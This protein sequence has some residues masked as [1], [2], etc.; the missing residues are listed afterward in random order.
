MLTCFDIGG[1]R[2]KPGWAT[3]PGRL[4]LLPEVPTP[5]DFAGLV[6]VMAGAVQPGSR[7]VSVS[8]AGVVPPETGRLNA[9]NVAAAHGHRLAVDLQAALG[10]P[11]WIANDA[12][13]FALAEATL[14]AGRGHRNLFGLIL[15]S[16]VGGG[17]VIDG[18][19]VTGVGGY[20]G[21]WGHGQVLAERLPNLGLDIPQFPCGC[22]QQGCID[23][24]GGA[25]GIERLYRHI[26]GT[27]LSSTAILSD[28]LTAEPL[29]LLVIDAWVA[30]LAGPLA[31]VLN[32]TGSSAVPVGGG[33]AN[34]PELI[35][36]LDQTVRARL[37]RQTDAALIVP[38]TLGTDAG[39]IGAAM[40]GFQGLGFQGLAALDKEQSDG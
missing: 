1:S 33:L 15:G 5:D 2:I 10:L 11:V 7:G 8:I 16:G 27:D 39:L 30:L 21:E 32:V 9:A 20:A 29:A 17:L 13:C 4:A 12:D 19:I 34:V 40:L 14:G 35:A 23:T 37:L 25:R 18:R 36:L 26:A 3:A 31:V 38:A 22:G 28:W 24:V 6:A